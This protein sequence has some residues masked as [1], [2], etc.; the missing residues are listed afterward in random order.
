M[1]DDREQLC[2]TACLDCSRPSSASTIEESP[3]TITVQDERAPLK[4][5]SDED[6]LGNDQKRRL[7]A[8]ETESES[9][10]K[11]IWALNNEN[12]GSH[13][14]NGGEGKE[15]CEPSEP[16]RRVIISTFLLL[17]LLFSLH[18]NFN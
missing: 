2:A 16:D 11:A 18:C 3:E 6:L 10:E 17:L 7:V 5:K 12:K 14:E 1:Q 15:I 4:R 9:S 8:V 13:E